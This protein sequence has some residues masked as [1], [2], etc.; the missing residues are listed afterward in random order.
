MPVPSKLKTNY[1]KHDNFTNPTISCRNPLHKAQV[2][3][4]P[5]PHGD[6]KKSYAPENGEWKEELYKW[7]I[8]KTGL[9]QYSDNSG[10]KT[11]RTTKNWVKGQCC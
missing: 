4:V 11:I 7:F 10:H 9:S 2:E 3:K 1:A 6:N 5:R 8:L